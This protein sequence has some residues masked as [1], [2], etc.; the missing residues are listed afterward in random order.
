[1]AIIY[2]INCYLIE[3]YLGN[4]DW[5]VLKQEKKVIYNTPAKYAPIY[6]TV[7]DIPANTFSL[8]YYVKSE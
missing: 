3:Y 7:T 6:R 4:V 8:E 2:L 1:M 5:D